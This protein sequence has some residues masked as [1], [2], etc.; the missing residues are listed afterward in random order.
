M[1]VEFGDGY[2]KHAFALPSGKT[3]TV[4]V[5]TNYTPVQ[6]GVYETWGNVN[7]IEALAYGL[8]ALK[9]ELMHPE[10]ILVKD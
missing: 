8:L 2:E 4:M 5:C 6:M 1:R 7:D 9:R 10:G 3:C